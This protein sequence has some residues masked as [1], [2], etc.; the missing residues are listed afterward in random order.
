MGGVFV[1][2][3]SDRARE[4]ERPVRAGIE[5]FDGNDGID[6]ERAIYVRERLD[7]GLRLLPAD[8]RAEALLVD[9]EQDKPSPAAP[10]TASRTSPGEVNCRRDQPRPA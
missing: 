5:L 9:P 1:R 3:F 10:E 7:G 4:F 2:E 8:F 6:V